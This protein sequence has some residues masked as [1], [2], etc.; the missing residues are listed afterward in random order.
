MC[1]L[2]L[3]R[4]SGRREFFLWG[5]FVSDVVN[6]NFFS[7]LFALCYVSVLFS[8]SSNFGVFS[9]AVF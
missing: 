4:L 9:I 7:V 2:W 5:G 6:V 1:V 3:R 8:F